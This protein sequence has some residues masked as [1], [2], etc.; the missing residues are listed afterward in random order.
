V[1]LV[2]KC[3]GHGGA[4]RL[5]VDVVAGADRSAV[6]YEVALVLDA[7]DGYVPLLEA[8][9]TT[10]HRLG[11]TGNRDLRW[12]GRLRRLVGDGGYDAV[13][14][15]LPYAAALGRPVVH[16]LPRGRRPATVTTEHSLWDKQAV[17]LRALNRLTIGRDVTLVVVSDA[18]AAALPP[19]LRARARVVVHGID[20]SPSADLVAR[21]PE[22]RAGVRDELDV[23][24]DHALV[25]CV[26]NLRAE[27]GHDV[28]LDAGAVLARDGVPATVVVVGRGPEEA[29][30]SARHRALD[31]GDRHRFLGP[32]DDVLRLMAAADVVV[33]PSRHEGLPVTLME[34]TSV[35]ACVVASAVGGVPQVVTDGLDGLLVPP[36]DPAALAAA[37]AR[38]VGDPD[39][40]ARLGRAAADGS[41][42]YDV[43]AACR[44]L[45]ALYRSPSG[46]GR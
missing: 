2:I 45:E 35:G 9:G 34:A 15:H 26:A 38:V 16:S 14:F 44:T 30:L 11:A 4:E 21:R 25:V 22:V 28:L 32:R 39:L 31:L 17:V 43:A 36:G 8:R 5:L 7:E 40:R 3:L 13:H 23:P 29:A 19:A 20:R 37:L 6:E 12:L 1:L 42:R 41:G 10:V 27:K 24:A 18:A 46:A 33:L